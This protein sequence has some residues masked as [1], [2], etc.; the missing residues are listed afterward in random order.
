MVA[1]GIFGLAVIH[2][3][4]ASSFKK[5]AASYPQGSVAENF[6]H[7]LGEV[8]VVFGLWAS[9]LLLIYAALRGG[10]ESVAYLEARDFTEPLFVFAIMVVAS[11]RPVVR[12]VETTLL[13]VARAV[14]LPRVSGVYFTCLFV[15][16]LLG[17]FVTEPAAMS[18]TALALREF[19][20]RNTT[21]SRFKYLTLGTLLVNVSIGGAM[22]PFAAPPILMVAKIWNWTPAFVAA[23]YGWKVALACF[24][25]AA[26]AAFAVRSE[27]KGKTLGTSP[28]KQHVTPLWLA[29]LHL[30]ALACIVAFSHHA[31]VF[32]GVLMLFLGL[33]DVTREYQSPLKLRESLLVAFFLAGLVV[34]GGLQ[35]WWLQPLLSSVEPRELF[36][37]ATGLTAITDNAALTYLGAQVPQVT[38]AFQYALVAGAIAGGGLTV[39]AN[40]P[41]PVA[42]SVLQEKFGVGGVKPGRLALAAALPT[43]IA[44]AALW[45][46]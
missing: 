36:L 16:P 46:L 45:L 3:F 8:E 44:M 27:L 35:R 37:L 26:I 38:E 31:V 39:M 34:L 2:T 24:V 43:L 14:P 28:E 42:F 18:V 12:V 32:L 19:F 17:S 13:T 25:N 15:G 4:L 33:A 1:G 11:S 20:F 40:A 21:S 10:A 22:T 30:A 7:L 9:V 29:F 5:V 41:N 6:W 23:A